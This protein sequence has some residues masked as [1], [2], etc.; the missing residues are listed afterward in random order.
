MLIPSAFAASQNVMPST[1]SAK[2]YLNPTLSKKN[3]A[4]TN[5]ELRAEFGS[6]S[7]WSMKTTLSYHGSEVTQPFSKH[8]PDPTGRSF[9]ND[10]SASGAIGVKYRIDQQSSLNFGT[11]LRV[12]TPFHGPK[13]LDT[14]DPRIA[15]DIFYRWLSLQMMSSVSGSYITTDVYQRNGQ[16]S[17][18]QA[19]QFVKYRMG[20]SRLSFSFKT[21]LSYYAF[22]RAYQEN[23]FAYASQYGMGFYPGLDYRVT[24]WLQVQTSLSKSYSNLRSEEDPFTY[25][26]GDL[27]QRLGLGIS[28][29]DEIYFYP[30]LSFFP[31]DIRDDSTSVSFN[32]IFSVF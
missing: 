19:S 31:E 30:Y 22:D 32:T 2:G 6:R 10:T 26:G 5:P 8:Q 25:D 27:T 7:R 1:S 4:I 17:T 12:D 20:V 24:D 3:I 13:K 28:L 14:N 16:V 29:S 15:Y 23:D 18:L 21:I 9:F 11:G